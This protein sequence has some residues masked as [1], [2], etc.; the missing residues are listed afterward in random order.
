MTS[1]PSRPCNKRLRLIAVIVVIFLSI[2]F[3]LG[4]QIL[5]MFGPDFA[6]G[7]LALCISACGASIST[8]FSEAPYYLQFMG[9]NR[10]VV[11]SISLTA[12]SMVSLSFFLGE[13]YGATGV[14]LAYA[15]PTTLLFCGLKLLASRHM[16]QYLTLN[17]LA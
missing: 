7:Y 17:A 10:L 13:H 9:R 11:G 15:A 14:A 6:Q 5:G 8:L 16:R 1:A 3:S 4:H 2:I 12:I